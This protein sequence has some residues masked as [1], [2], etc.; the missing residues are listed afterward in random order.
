MKKTALMESDKASSILF[1]SLL[2]GLG[3]YFS[4][5][6]P[7]F[8]YIG[9]AMAMCLLFAAVAAAEDTDADDD[10]PKLAP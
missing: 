4:G 9:T 8:G 5:Y 6:N 2:M 1:T 7:F 3:C 10:K